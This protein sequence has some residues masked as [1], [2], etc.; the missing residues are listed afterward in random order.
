[1]L[2][3][4]TII[5]NSS[6]RHCNVLNQNQAFASIQKHYIYLFIKILK[7]HV[8]TAIKQYVY[9][10]LTVDGRQA[11]HALCVVIYLLP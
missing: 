2:K 5:T 10:F 8:F 6:F 7:C 1:M 3:R 4:L 9:S 11:G